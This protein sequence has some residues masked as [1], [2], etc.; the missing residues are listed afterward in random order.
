MVVNAVLLNL[1]HMLNNLPKLLN[2][3]FYSLREV[4]EYLL[5][6]IADRSLFVC[7]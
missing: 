7:D 3:Q 5:Q 6:E 2:E 1:Q 4:M